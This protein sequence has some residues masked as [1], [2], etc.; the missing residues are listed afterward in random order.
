[1]KESKTLK[2]GISMLFLLGLW[3]Y[4]VMFCF[5][6]GMDKMDFGV[7]FFDLKVSLESHAGICINALDWIHATWFALEVSANS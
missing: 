2:E 4:C 5:L 1:M 7:F 6:K 3:S